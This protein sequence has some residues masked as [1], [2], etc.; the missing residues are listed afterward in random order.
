MI[1]RSQYWIGYN[2]KQCDNPRG[3]FY[4]TR[5]QRAIMVRADGTDRREIGASLLKGENT[6]TQF[7]CWWPDG[8]A[9]VLAMWESPENFAWERENQRFRFDKGCWASD[10]CLVD[11]DADT[12]ANLT[13]VK[14]VSHWNT[15]MTPWP[16]DPSRASFVAIVDGAIRPF[17]M[18]LDGTDKRQV[19]SGEG[20]FTYG[21]QP[22]PDGRRIAYLQDYK[23]YLADPNG[24]NARRVDE[25]PKRDFQ[26][27]PAW[28]PDGQWLEF[29]AGEH[30]DCHPHTIRADGT[31]LRKLADRGGYR[32]V[33]ETLDYPDFHSESS[34]GPVWSRDSH[35]LYYTA[36]VGQAVELMRVSVDGQ[37][38]QLTRSKPGV[39][40]YHPNVSPDSR[41]V[42]FGST[43]DGARALYVVD[44]DGSNVQ[45][46]TAPTTGRAQLW[47]NWRPRAGNR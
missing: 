41:L 15:G 9:V 12:A 33:I 43:R 16:G 30:Y 7:V 26:F 36:K 38:Q 17:T 46:I 27:A 45:A 19:I 24:S 14:R 11:V 28:S 23:L 6:W 32:G 8:R 18:C 21:V 3:Q 1:E 31:G 37:V 25:D 42:V 2:D 4:N 5:T 22:S 20:K 13:T 40:H 35:W 44:A 39:L 47:A 34:D 29:L 10:V